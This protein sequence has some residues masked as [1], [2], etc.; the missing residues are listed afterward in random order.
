[1]SASASRAAI[2]KSFAVCENLADVTAKTGSQSIL[3]SLLG[4]GLGIGLANILGDVVTDE[5][6]HSR[7]VSWVIM[8]HHNHHNRYYVLC[9]S[10]MD[11]QLMD[12]MTLPATSMMQHTAQTTVMFLSLSILGLMA[13]YWS[14]QHV[15]LSTLTRPK[16][17]Y[18]MYDYILQRQ[19]TS[20]IKSSEQSANVRSVLINVL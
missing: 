4:T 7:Q 20:K 13:N 11:F 9:C 5:T 15:T 17:T 16:L 6:L 19:R 14:L 2:H 12:I 18:V 8:Y 1:M 10:G 3:S